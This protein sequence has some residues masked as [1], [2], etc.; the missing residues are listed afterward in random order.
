MIRYTV[1]STA[2]QRPVL[3]RC[4]IPSS[5]IP[6]ASTCARV[7]RPNWGSAIEAQW[8]SGVMQFVVEV[9]PGWHSDSI[10]HR[11]VSERCIGPLFHHSAG[12]IK[13]PAQT[14]CLRRSCNRFVRRPHFFRGSPEDHSGAVD[15]GEPVGILPSG[16]KAEVVR[17][18]GA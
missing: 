13:E 15:G 4:L 17:I 10:H 18:L 3:M 8:R 14:W 16:L 2:S 7:R 9:N 5:V 1:G 12:G 11:V 6:Q